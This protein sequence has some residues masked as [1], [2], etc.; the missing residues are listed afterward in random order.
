MKFSPISFSMAGIT[1]AIA[2][3]TGAVTLTFAPQMTEVVIAQE[4]AP[5]VT[6]ASS[7]GAIGLADHL[8]KTGAKLYTA[9]W[10]PHCHSQKQRFGKQALETLVVIECDRRGINPQ[11]QLC[12]D[13]RVRAY[14]TWEINGNMYAGSRSLETLAELSGYR[15]KLYITSN[16]FAEL[17]AN[18]YR[19]HFVGLLLI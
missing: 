7:T 6:T 1:L 16:S 3:L 18:F 11:T 10:C 13:K 15:G 8:R 4:A 14:P 5:E 17:T 2:S 19:K 9:Y 12:Q